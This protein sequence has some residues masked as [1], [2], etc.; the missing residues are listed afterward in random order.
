MCCLLELTFV[1]Q[2]IVVITAQFAG[3]TLHSDDVAAFCK[4]VSHEAGVIATVD[5]GHHFPEVYVTVAEHLAFHTMLVSHAQAYA[6]DLYV[7]GYENI[8]DPLDEA[9]HEVSTMHALGLVTDF[10]LVWHLAKFDQEHNEIARECHLLHE[11]MA[12][13]TEPQLG[14]CGIAVA[15]VSNC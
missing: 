7:T 8:P 4:Q 12:V 6:L 14:K 9:Q 1:L 11:C 2:S 3:I 10:E 15:H 5:W 13:H